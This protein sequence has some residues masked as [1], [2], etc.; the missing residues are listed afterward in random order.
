MSSQASV[1]DN[2]VK[3][4]HRDR[5]AT[6]YQHGNYDYL[7]DEIASR[8]VDRLNDVSPSKKFPVAVDL[9]AFSGHVRKTLEYTAKNKGISKLHQLEQSEML[10]NRDKHQNHP[11]GVDVSY[12]VWDEDQKLP[13]DTDSIDVVF[14]SMAL[15]WINDL[16]GVFKEVHRVLKPDGVFL[17]AMLGGA[18]LQELRSSFAVAEQERKGGL[19]PHVSPFVRDGEIGGLIQAAGFNLPTADSDL[20]TVKYPDI[21]TMMEHLRGMGETNATKIRQNYTP[22]DTF[23]AAAAAYQELYTD[24][25]DLLEATF[26]VLYLIGWKPHESQQTPDERG[27]GSTRLSATLA[28]LASG[29]LNPGS[30]SGGGTK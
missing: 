19:S 5:I 1:F 20:L 7:R 17:G 23:I 28:E 10:L 8:L 18:T 14:S 29:P 22:I 15:H 6:V 25:D 13:F 24:D 9:G 30:F 12:S 3:K 2:K 16:P 26:H 4:A 27:S 21:F 11:D